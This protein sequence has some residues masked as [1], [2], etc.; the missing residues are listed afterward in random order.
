[1]LIYSL[2]VFLLSFFPTFHRRSLDI[3][4]QYFVPLVV[5]GQGVFDDEENW[6][7]VLNIIPDKG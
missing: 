7:K 4:K 3:L 6:K 5:E 1:M 2:S